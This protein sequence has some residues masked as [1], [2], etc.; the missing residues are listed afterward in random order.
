MILFYNQ[1]KTRKYIFSLFFFYCFIVSNEIYLIS[2]KKI[3]LRKHSILIE[4]QA[5]LQENVTGGPTITSERAGNTI[6]L[7]NIY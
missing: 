5:R 6:A 3:S 7:S 2:I 1:S 4:S